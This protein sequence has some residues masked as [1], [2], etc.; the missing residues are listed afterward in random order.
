[1]LDMKNIT[2]GATW[3]SSSKKG[4]FSLFQHKRH[5][6]SIL[7]KT[8]YAQNILTPEILAQL[9]TSDAVLKDCS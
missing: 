8:F 7:T 1:M 2:E 3:L 5:R 9:I 6:N 4:L